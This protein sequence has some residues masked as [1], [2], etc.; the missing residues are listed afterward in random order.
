[1]EAEENVDYFKSSHYPLERES[2]V[3]QPVRQGF[4]SGYALVRRISW[5][6]VSIDTA[7]RPAIYF[8]QR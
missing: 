1:M 3:F 2:I 6:F 8:G 4:L 5:L 7:M